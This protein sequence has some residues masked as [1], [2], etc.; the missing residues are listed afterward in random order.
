MFK[1]DSNSYTLFILVFL[2]F[3]FTFVLLPGLTY[4]QDREARELEVLGDTLFQS[5]SIEEL[6]NIQSE[7]QKRIER[8]SDE[9]NKSRNRG[10]EVTEE[11]LKQEG[12]NIKDKDKILIRLA[13]Y[14]YDEADDQ[15]MLV[16]ESYNVEYLKYVEQLDKFYENQLEIEPTEPP[17]PKYDYSKVIE[18]YD[19]ILSEYPNS[20]FADDALYTK[21]YLKQQMDQGVES[22]KIYQ[23]VI[24]RYPESHFAADSYMRL[25][26]YYFDPREDKDTEQTIVELQRAIRLY[27]KVLQYRD[28]KR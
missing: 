6:K 10:K 27:K 5:M 26:E 14:Y 21:A 28:S 22:R 4:A 13:E 19:K 25:A 24:D 18:V 8:I 15:Y 9:E 11:F 12:G 23:E 20:D 16:N 17:Q 7:Y 1:I 3:S 2:I